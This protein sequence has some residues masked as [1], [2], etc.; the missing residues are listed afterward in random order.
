MSALGA[1]VEPFLYVLLIWILRERPLWQGLVL[2]MGFL[3]REFTVYGFMAFLVVAALDRSL[4][5]RA[6]HARRGD[7]RGGGGGMDCRVGAPSLLQR[8]RAR[9]DATGRGRRLQQ[10]E[11]PAGSRVR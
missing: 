2:G 8:G 1:S 6:R 9:H 4:F 3:H 5:T 11:G 10:P 7:A